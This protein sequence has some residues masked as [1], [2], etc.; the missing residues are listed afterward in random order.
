MRHFLSPCPP[1]PHPRRMRQTAPAAGLVAPAG[2]LQ[3][4][5]AGPPRA[6]AGAVDLPAVAATA[7]DRLD[8]AGHAQE[9][10]AAA[11]LCR[12][13]LGNQPW[14]SLALAGIMPLHACPA[15]CV[16]HGVDVE[17]PSLGRRRAC[18]T[19]WQISASPSAT[20]CP[21]LPLLQP[22]SGPPAA[23]L[24][25]VGQPRPRPSTGA[26]YDL[27]PPSPGE[28]GPPL[29]SGACQRWSRRTAGGPRPRR[30][31]YPR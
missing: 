4:P 29:T 11:R 16:G 1:A 13:R 24:R 5:P 20:T 23:P 8:T 3:R 21:W 2:R 18:P 14:T 17:P 26:S 31:G 10:P 7:D 28:F 27:S 19:F 30:R 12:H 25:P 22:I 15:R 9:Q 6:R